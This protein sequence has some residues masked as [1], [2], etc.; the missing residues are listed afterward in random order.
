MDIFKKKYVEKILN[1]VEDGVFITDHKGVAIWMNN[2]SLK[3]LGAPRSKLIGMDVDTLEEAGYFTPSVTKEVIQHGKDISKVQESLN[4]QYLA[5]GK[6]LSFQGGEQ[7]LILAQVKDITETVRASLKVEKA[8]YLLKK[9]WDELQQVKDKPRDTGQPLIIGNS[10]AHDEMMRLIDQIAPYDATILLQGET[11]VGKSMIA[12][13][14]HHR[15]DRHKA[16]FM[17]INCG[18]IPETLLESELFGYKKGA[19]TGANQTGK[20]GLV[21]KAN[22]G[23]LF[24]DEI[25]EL[26]MTL[27][28]KILQLIQDKTFIPIG[29]TEI[30]Q[31]DIRIISATNEDLIRKIDE[32]VFR[33]DLYYR[34]NVI[35]VHIPSL[36]ERKSD[37]IP[38]LYHYLNVYTIKYGKNIT[39]TDDILQ[40]LQY[41]DWP[42][43]IRELENIVER[44]VVTTT[45]NQINIE[46][47]PEN[48]QQLI[49]AIEIP[50]EEAF[51]EQNLQQYLEGIEKSIIEKAQIRFSST[52][53][54]A[55]YLGITQSSYMRRLKKYDL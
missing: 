16:P 13:E 41:Y 33:K 50:F 49:T 17:Q 45:T 7:D 38:L 24:L 40:I 28:P 53:K 43:N 9:Y 18:A 22:G 35:S 26:P 48:I 19:F 25:A 31:V 21:E 46:Q 8:E 6:R 1:N 12:K 4:R 27:Q 39:L 29:A 47:L 15:S 23:T 2:T 37:I 14:I 55:Q 5:T 32:K 42:G 20:V 52:R 36:R 30:E 3:Q 34:L 10:Q 51:D 44:L 54:A 11:G